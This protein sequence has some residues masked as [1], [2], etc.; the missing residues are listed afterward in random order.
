MRN[1]NYDIISIPSQKVIWVTNST[2]FLNLYPERKSSHLFVWMKVNDEPILILHNPIK[3]KT[4]N[5]YMNHL[6]YIKVTPWIE[7][8]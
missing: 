2:A 5:Q 1:F 4:L 6:N 7:N 3:M 8:D